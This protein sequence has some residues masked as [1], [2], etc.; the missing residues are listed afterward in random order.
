MRATT[1]GKPEQNNFEQWG[2]AGEMRFLPAKR[3]KGENST[4]PERTREGRKWQVEAIRNRMNRG[5]AAATER[6]LE[7]T[8]GKQE[9]ARPSAKEPE[10][11]KARRKKGLRVD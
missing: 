7:R 5:K 6:R 1:Q 2:P 3:L 10:G 11:E 4:N 9:K 8:S